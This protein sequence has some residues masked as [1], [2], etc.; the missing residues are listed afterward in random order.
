MNRLLCLF[1]LTGALFSC[2][3]PHQQSPAPSNPKTGSVKIRMDLGKD[4]EVIG[5][6]IVEKT[7]AMTKIPPE[8]DRAIL[9]R[10]RHW[11]FSGVT[12]T[13]FVRITFS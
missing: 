12:G 1:L 5:A 13:K 8:D 3:A 9:D 4:G 2:T 11:K 7:G 10:V 6:T